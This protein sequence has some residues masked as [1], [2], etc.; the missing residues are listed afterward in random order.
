MAKDRVLPPL[1][2]TV[3]DARRFARHV[4]ARQFDKTG[5]L[6]MGHL[7]RVHERATDHAGA[8]GWA[9]WPDELS[10]RLQQIALLHDVIEDGHA[11]GD[12]LL[13]EGFS[14]GVVQGVR[15]LTKPKG[16]PYADYIARVCGE[17]GLPGLA[18]ILIKLADVEDNS[19]PD[20]LALLDEATRARLLAK[21]EPARVVLE[22]QARMRGW[23]SPSALPCNAA[24]V[25]GDLE[26]ISD[27]APRAQRV[28]AFLA[29]LAAFDGPAPEE[30]TT[31]N[32]NRTPNSRSAR[33]R[34]KELGYA[35]RA[36]LPNGRYG[37]AITDRGRK[38]LAEGAAYD[39]AFQGLFGVGEVT[40]YLEIRSIPEPS[41][42]C[43]LWLG[44][45]DR[46]GYGRLN[47][48]GMRTRF[49]HRI[50]YQAR[51]GALP[52]DL[53]L[54]H[55]CRVR[56]C[57]NTDHL[58]PVTSAENTRRG[59]AGSERRGQ[60]RVCRRGHPLS[61]ENVRLSANGA[62]ACKQCI[63]DRL[64]ARYAERRSGMICQSV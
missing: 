32:G 47:W 38:A 21:Y 54:D 31:H 58:E 28:H 55:K 41:S 4:H 43:L 53:V 44:N 22:A 20:R 12:D 24:A 33:N 61:G 49:A 17:P 36:P 14:M 25:R 8:A 64:R 63:N 42:G 62:R 39:L 52:D 50:A 7:I 2:R 15:A 27:T 16:M 57:I 18:L 29:V 3:D 45:L 40:A 9:A 5:R 10:D 13:A 60:V 51:Y 59:N 34:A 30:A 11:T 26:T 19:D 1:C 46:H 48:K 23:V 56:C 35:V 37:W 6:Y